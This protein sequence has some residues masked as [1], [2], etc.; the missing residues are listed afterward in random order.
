MSSLFS[1]NRITRALLLHIALSGLLWRHITRVHLLLH[2][3]GI[4]RGSGLSQALLLL[5][6]LPK[7]IN[8][9]DLIDWHEA[10]ISFL[11]SCIQQN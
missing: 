10:Q 8:E 5:N 6:H 7:I 9:S 4:A 2:I 3:T 11:I 1:T